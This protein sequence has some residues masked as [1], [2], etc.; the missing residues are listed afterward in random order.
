QTSENQSGLIYVTLADKIYNFTLSIESRKKTAFNASTRVKMEGP[1]GYLDAGEYP[2]LPFYLIM[3]LVY[4]TY[5]IVWLTVSF[6]QW[7]DLL[8]IQFWIG[9]VIMLGMLEKAIFY[10]EK[11]SINSNGYSVPE[12]EIAA[13]IVS[14]TK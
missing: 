3:C 13:E 11:Q 4:V 8:R 10:A 6:L 7:R 12:A 9:G 1:N 2:L 14:C 5:G